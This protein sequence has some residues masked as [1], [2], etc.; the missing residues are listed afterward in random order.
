MRVGATSDLHGYLPPY[1]EEQLDLMLVAGD[2]GTI[3]GGGDPYGELAGWIE[4]A[5]CPVV[6]IAG[7]MD[8][9]FEHER[10]LADRLPWTYLEDETTEVEGL[11]IHGSPWSLKFAGCFQ[12]REEDLR[13][14]AWSAIPESTEILMTHG[15]ARGTGDLVAGDEHVGSESLAEAIGYMSGL[16]LHVFGHIHTGYGRWEIDG[17]IRANVSHLRADDR[18]ANPIQVFDL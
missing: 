18:P 6:G 8:F 12:A 1:P 11:L 15:P 2:V 16:R 13:R 10:A 14:Y 9:D 7:N 4:E 5:G 3:R 17:S